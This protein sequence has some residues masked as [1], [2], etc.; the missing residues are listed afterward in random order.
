M[1]G[2]HAMIVLRTPENLKQ[3]GAIINS[4]WLFCAQQNRPLAVEV[5]E[6]KAKRNTRQ[7]R[8]Y[9]AIVGQITEQAWLEGKQWPNHVWHD[10]L[11]GR[12][13]GFTEGMNGRKVPVSTTDLSVAEFATY[14]EQVQSFAVDEL[15]IELDVRS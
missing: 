11:A 7:N 14:V 1:P 4:N 10:Y 5:F 3:A 8:L 2:L 9:W 15:G 12:F 6:H 13:I